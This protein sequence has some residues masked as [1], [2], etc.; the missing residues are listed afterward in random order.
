MTRGT[1][2]EGCALARVGDLS[3]VAAA[4]PSERVDAAGY[5]LGVGTWSPRSLAVLRGET[6]DPVR[7]ITVAL[8]TPEYLVH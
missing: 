1:A 7:L 8:N 3:A 6:A 4:A 5:L 2:G